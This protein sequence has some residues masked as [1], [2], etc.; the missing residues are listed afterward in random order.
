MKQILFLILVLFSLASCQ[1][2]ELVVIDE[3]SKMWYVTTT[4]AKYVDTGD[5]VILQYVNIRQNYPPSFYGIYEG[6]LP[7]PMTVKSASNE[8]VK[9]DLHY[10]YQKGRVLDKR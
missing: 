4:Y 5:S 3:N 7:E 9:Y 2:R 10:T 8:T 1:D 6:K